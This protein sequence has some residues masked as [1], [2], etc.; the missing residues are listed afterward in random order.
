M[1]RLVTPKDKTIWDEF[2][3]SH[4]QGT[5][6]HLFG[7]QKVLIESSKHRCFYLIAQSST[8]EVRG[9][10]PLA[11][12]Q[13]VIFGKVLS[14]TPYCMYGG[15]LA[16]DDEQKQ[17]LEARACELA[18]ELNVDYLELRYKHKQANIHSD[19][20]EKSVHSIFEKA[21]AQSPDDILLGIKKK[22]RAVV[23]HS[24]KNELN[25][26]INDDV[27][28]LYHIYS[29]SVRNLG[30]PVFPKKLFYAL[31]NEFGDK[32]DVTTVYD[33]D[34]ALSS[35]MSFYYKNT[36]MPYYGGGLTEARLTKSNDHMYYKLMCHAAEN[37]CDNFDFG[38]SKNDSGAF[39]YKQTWGIEAQPIY[40]YYYLVKA[41]ELPNLNPN[42]PKYEM[43]INLWKKLPLPVSQ[44]L[45]PFVSKYLG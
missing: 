6:C 3:H 22:Q 45:G 28:T 4:A 8:G 15:A 12:T 34:K 39:K 7:W 41:S 13:S 2:V 27:D 38:R 24:L 21:L 16:V 42:N 25:T 43:V 17:A 37:G 1:I 18:K 32:V 9:V 30:T 19:F 35:V 36:V 20:S 23:R 40:H 5:F 14:S 33:K 44:F 29:S 10:L 26:V 11:M 31:K